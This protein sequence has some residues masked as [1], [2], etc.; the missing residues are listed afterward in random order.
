MQ[1][2]PLM[3]YHYV[4]PVPPLPPGTHQVVY[5]AVG[6]SGPNGTQQFPKLSDCDLVEIL[7]PMISNK[8]M[9]VYANKG[10]KELNAQN[11]LAN[12][13]CIVLTAK[14]ILLNVEKAHGYCSCECLRA[15]RW[16]QTQKGRAGDLVFKALMICMDFAA[17]MIQLN[18]IKDLKAKSQTEHSISKVDPAHGVYHTYAPRPTAPAYTFHDENIKNIWDELRKIEESENSVREHIRKILQGK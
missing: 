10:S 1:S 7:Y 9:H 5:H 8:I 16:V 13:N 12:I 6:P 15:L 2:T 3:S 14:D 11:I 4:Y 18:C 17:L